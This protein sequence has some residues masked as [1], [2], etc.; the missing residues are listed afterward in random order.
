[1]SSSAQRI[2]IYNNV[3][4][5]AIGA[6]SAGVDVRLSR[7]TS[8]DVYGSIRPWKRTEDAVHKHW[9]VQT[10][11]RLWPCQVMNGF[12]WGPY[13]HV[14]EFNIGNRDLLFGVLRSLKPYRY[15]GWMAGVGMGVGY[16]F[17]LTRHLNIGVEAGAGYTYIDY[18]KYNCEVCGVLKEDSVYHYFGPSRLGVNIIFVF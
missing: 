9:L 5:D 13:A 15:E 11:L 3:F 2:A 10:Q 12:F 14:A 18:R 4:Y 8:L 7:K 6:L 1:M 17:A 16:E